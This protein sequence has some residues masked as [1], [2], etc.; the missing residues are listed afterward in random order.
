[1][2]INNARQTWPR[3]GATAAL[4]R[5][6][7]VLNNLCNSGLASG[8][9]PNTPPQAPDAGCDDARALGD[10]CAEIGWTPNQ[11]AHGDLVA[12]DDLFAIASLQFLVRVG[13]LLVRH[14][15]PAAGRRYR[16]V[17]QIVFDQL[18]TRTQKRA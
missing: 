8:G 17:A 6:A 3:A 5:A 18:A 15:P 1:M 14:A 16:C 7:D 12:L 4:A 11:L 2:T 9:R 13:A 10:V